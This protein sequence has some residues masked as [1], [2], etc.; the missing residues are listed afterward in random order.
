[1]KKVIGYIIVFMIIAV[2]SLIAAY[3]QREYFAIGGEVFI[4]FIAF[5]I[6]YVKSGNRV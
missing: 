4:P 2:V 3:E 1:M 6:Y 5:V